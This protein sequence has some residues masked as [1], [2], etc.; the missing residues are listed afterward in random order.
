MLYAEKLNNFYKPRIDCDYLKEKLGSRN[1]GKVLKFIVNNP[2]CVVE[3]IN[4]FKKDSDLFWVKEITTHFTTE[5]KYEIDMDID[6]LLGDMTPGFIIKSMEIYGG[7]LVNSNI[8]SYTQPTYLGGN[9]VVY[10]K[11]TFRDY[12][13]E[14]ERKMLYILIA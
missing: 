4:K 13:G 2:N 1:L 11:K 5:S 12:S 6:V 8:L 3:V 10:K 9:L 14:E 7:K